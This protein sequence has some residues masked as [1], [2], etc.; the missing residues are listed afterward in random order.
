MSVDREQQE[1]ELEFVT[2]AY[3]LDEAWADRDAQGTAVVSLRLRT[4][5]AR[6]GFHC[7]IPKGYPDNEWCLQVNGSVDDAFKDQQGGVPGFCRSLES[8]S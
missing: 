6:W 1:T 7:S 3:A 2:S 5:D 4:T 8:L